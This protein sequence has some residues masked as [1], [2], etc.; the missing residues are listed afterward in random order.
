MIRVIPAVAIFCAGLFI[1]AQA[2][3]TC[4]GCG[5]IGMYKPNTCSPPSLSCVTVPGGIIAW[6]PL[7]TS[8]TTWNTSTSD[9]SGNSN[10]LDLVNMTQA[11]NSISGQI[12]QAISFAK[13][14]SNYMASAST[15]NYASTEQVSI[16]IWLNMAS[17]DNNDE[18]AMESSTNYNNTYGTFI[19]DPNSSTGSN[20][21]FEFGWDTG[22]SAIT[23]AEF[24]RPSTGAWH[25]YVFEIDGSKTGSLAIPV[26]Y[27]D[28]VS[29][30]LTYPLSGAG[31][32]ALSNQT[33]YVM[34]RAGTTLFNSGELDDV[35]IYNRLLSSSDVTNIYNSGIAGRP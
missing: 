9:L 27:V 33:L 26:I 31:V 15:I 12:Q 24:T 28:A 11:S 16:S 7:D 10:T 3:D 2:Q 13:A 14:S 35:R 25:H 34:S 8:T 17:F 23:S 5:V 29:Q 19:I 1:A 32:L 4:I 30:T 20:Q 22:F 6:W 21:K 18:L